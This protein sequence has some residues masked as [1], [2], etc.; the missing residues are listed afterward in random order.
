M[1]E[2]LSLICSLSLYLAK[3][4]PTVKLSVDERK[5]LLVFIFGPTLIEKPSFDL[6]FERRALEIK[7]EDQQRSFASSI[8]RT[9]QDLGECFPSN[10]LGLS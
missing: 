6:K 1:I 4:P 10:P 3:N 8:A 9:C 5:V 2:S 7:F